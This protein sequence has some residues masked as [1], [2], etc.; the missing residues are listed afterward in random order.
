MFRNSNLGQAE[1]FAHFSVFENSSL[2]W[3]NQ[4]W[5]FGLKHV[6]H[7]KSSKLEFVINELE[8]CSCPKMCF[9]DKI[10]KFVSGRRKLEFQL[11]T[12]V[13]TSK[14]SYKLQFWKAN[15]SFHR[16]VWKSNC[17]NLWNLLV[18]SWYLWSS[19]IIIP[20]YV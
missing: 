18:W 16:W 17:L 12:P 7:Y 15:S 5:G 2:P 10:T 9:K 3:K 1:S 6:L 19:L 14:H 20:N 13:L 4:F 11:E 8:F